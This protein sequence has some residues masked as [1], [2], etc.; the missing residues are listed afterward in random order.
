MLDLC[1]HLQLA[2]AHEEQAA[3]IVTATVLEQDREYE[4]TL[5]SMEDQTVTVA[6]IDA[7]PGTRMRLRIPARDI[8]L[9]LS[10]PQQSSILNVLRARITEIENASNS[11]LLVRLQVGEQFLLARLTRK[12]IVTLRLTVGCEVYAQIKSVA[13]LS[14][15]HE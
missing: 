8:S 10:P 1:S 3:A 2:I 11:K 9:C 12:S 7:D 13:L 15:V 6:A 14:H 4:L 5:L